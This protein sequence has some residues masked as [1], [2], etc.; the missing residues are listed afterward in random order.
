[1]FHGKLRLHTCRVILLTSLVWFLVVVVVLSFYSEC[2][3]GACKKP[4]E[5]NVMIPGALVNDNSNSNTNNQ[6]DQLDINDHENNV[7][8]EETSRYIFNTFDHI[9][10]TP[11][12]IQAHP[13]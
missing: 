6:E 4:G 5:Y 11:H 9:H 2:L 3:G 8:R 10:N 13:V 1:M 12:L 7:D